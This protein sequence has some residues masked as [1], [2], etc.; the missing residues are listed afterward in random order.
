[1]SSVTAA[2]W[3]HPPAFDLTPSARHRGWFTTL[4]FAGLPR[5]RRHRH[6][7]ELH[8]NPMELA[9]SAEGTAARQE[10]E[11][12]RAQRRVVLHEVGVGDA[13]VGLVGLRRVYRRHAAFDLVGHRDLIHL[14]DALLLS[15]E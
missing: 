13:D 1:M 3:T 2:I 7:V 10:S 14:A 9:L 5:S 6:R 15:T 4:A 12:T 8:R 11:N